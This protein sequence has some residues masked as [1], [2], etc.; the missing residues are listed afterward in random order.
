MPWVAV[1]TVLVLL[2]LLW[3]ALG[4]QRNLS[5]GHALLR[6]LQAG[7]PR[8]GEKT[9]VRWLGSSAVM[10]Q[11]A[12]PAP[13]LEA[14]QVNVV[15]EPRD[16][17]FLW[18]W[19]RQRGRRDFVILRGTLPAPPRFDLEAGGS[20]R[21]WTG[22][23]RLRR[24]DPH[25]WERVRWEDDAGAIEVAHSDKVAAVDL[26]RAEEVW[27]QLAGATTAVWRLSVRNLA[28]HVEVHLQPPAHVATGKAE[29]ADEAAATVIG[30]FLDLAR[31]VA[32]P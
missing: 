23:D 22:A 28:P 31:L 26:A 7:L 3:F 25:A 5:R 11:I 16:V 24:L 17:G 14:A 1:G 18:A 10:L 12:D 30:A 21:G 6:W 15:L 2:F 8:L 19:A 13:P 4:T 27:H 9:T 20:G 29:G 32:R